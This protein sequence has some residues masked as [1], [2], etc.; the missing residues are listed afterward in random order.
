[1]RRGAVRA[2]TVDAAQF[3]PLERVGLEVRAKHLVHLARATA[4]DQCQLCVR[5]ATNTDDVLLAEDCTK[6]CRRLRPRLLPRRR[7]RVVRVNR[8]IAAQCGAGWAVGYLGFVVAG[9]GPAKSS[10]VCRSKLRGAC[11]VCETG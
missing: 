4:A 7:A 1:M 10:N 3:L 6:S 5:L 8:S 2:G 11:A 9:S